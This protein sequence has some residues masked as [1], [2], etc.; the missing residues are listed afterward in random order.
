MKVL[1]VVCGMAKIKLFLNAFDF[2]KADLN[3]MELS[4]QKSRGD[5]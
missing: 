5:I 1:C 4:N 2:Y 3:V